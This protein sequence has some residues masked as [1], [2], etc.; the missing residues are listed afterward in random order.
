M[1]TFRLIVLA[2][3]A[4]MV[5]VNLSSCSKD[6][7]DIDGNINSKKLVQVIESNLHSEENSSKTFDFSYDSKDRLISISK[8]YSS[9]D[10]RT[11]NY[12]WKN[13][14]ITEQTED[15]NTTY[16]LENNLVRTIKESDDIVSFSYNS[17][18]QLIAE[19][20][21]YEYGNTWTNEYVWDKDKL[22]SYNNDEQYIY[23]GRTCKG[24]N[25]LIFPND[26]SEGYDLF[27]AH[28]ELNGMRTQQLQDKVTTNYSDGS[29]L[30]V[31]Y[32]YTF[33]K[34]GYLETCT[35]NITN[36]YGSNVSTWKIIYTFTWE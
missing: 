2:V 21:T 27:L 16:N 12:I 26:F 15:G 28:P 10:I 25:P 6:N 5:S 24:Y 18:N 29:T 35:M 23:S 8:I 4:I 22:V 20:I 36:K 7:E 32:S 31:D 9:S 14:I 33:D 34:D 11:I 3:M 13:N 19:Q 30:V 17:S 1:K